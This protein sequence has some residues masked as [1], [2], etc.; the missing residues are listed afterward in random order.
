MAYDQPGS[1]P[2]VEP[3]DARHG[4]PEPPEVVDRGAVRVLVAAAAVVCVAVPLLVALGA[5]SALRFGAMLAAFCS[6][7][8]RC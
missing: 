6:P 8:A 3:I 7:P 4:R 1:T 2:M 5:P